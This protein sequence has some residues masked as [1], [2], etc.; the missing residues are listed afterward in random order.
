[1]TASH[2]FCCVPL[3]DGLGSHCKWN[4]FSWFRV[5]SVHH[6][7]VDNNRFLCINLLYFLWVPENFLQTRFLFPLYFFSLG[8]LLMLLFSACLCVWFVHIHTCAIRHWST[9]SSATPKNAIYLLWNRSS[10]SSPRFIRHVRL[11]TQ[12]SRVE[13]FLLPC[14]P[15]L[16][17]QVRITEAGCSR[18]VGT[19]NWTQSLMHT[20]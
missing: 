18:H 1:M 17:F 5:G 16:E 2:L 9:A 20:R 4:C 14:F 15:T 19:R 3:S 6:Q 7:H 10:L 12:S 13:L 8:F 11:A